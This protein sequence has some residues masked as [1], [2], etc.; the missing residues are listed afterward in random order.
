MSRLKFLSITV[1]FLVIILGST[2]FAEQ[3]PQPQ[4]AKAKIIEV[5]TFEHEGLAESD[6]KEITQQVALKI[7]SGKFKGKVVIVD[8]MASSMMGGEMILKPGDRV[9]LYVDENPPPAE[10]PDDEDDVISTCTSRERSETPASFLASN[11]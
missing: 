4:Y 10:S 5:Q 6:I 2:V 8:H 11:L 1:L 9:I 3:P 7:L